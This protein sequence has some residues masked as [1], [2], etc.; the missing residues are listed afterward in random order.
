VPIIVK[1]F[2]ESLAGPPFS[3]RDELLARS[4]ARDTLQSLLVRYCQ[5]SIGGRSILIAGHRG[6]GKTTLVKSVVEEV[7]KDT[8]LQL[9][10]EPL[11]VYLHGPDLVAG[12]DVLGGAKTK[13]ESPTTPAATNVFILR[14]G[15]SQVSA[16]EPSADTDGVKQSEQAR[17]AT[18]AL[19]QLTVA[20]HQAF[21]THIGWLMQRAAHK[22][23]R[24]EE[25]AQFRLDVDRQLD[26]SDLRLFWSRMGVLEKGLLRRSNP[27]TAVN[28]YHATQGTLEI[29]ALASVS[30]AYVRAIAKDVEESE[31]QELEEKRERKQEQQKSNDRKELVNAIAGLLSGGAVGAGVAANAASVPAKVLLGSLAFSIA[32]IL[33]SSILNL[34]TVHSF[35]QKRSKER[36]V[37]YDDSLG[38]L[39]LMVPL[40][41]RRVQDAGL[42][43]VFV[44]DELD[45]VDGLEKNM[46]LLL[47]QLKHIVADKSFTCFLVDRQYFDTLRGWETSIARS[48][49]LTFFGEQLYIIMRP[50]DWHSYMSQILEVSESHDESNE[51]MNLAAN[52]LGYVLLARAKMHAIGVRRELEKL[53]RHRENIDQIALAAIDILTRPD[54][55]HAFIYQLAVEFLLEDGRLRERVEAEP[56]FLQVAYDALYYLLNNWEKGQEPNWSINELQDY[57]WLC[58]GVR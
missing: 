5:R 11:F 27:D 4:R 36:K 25:A 12:V 33:T 55:Q 26:V 44:V 17:L 10:A 22:V 47:R 24:L 19:R 30:E 46:E 21:T 31:G 32:T 45:K 18:L 34:T 39:E 9:D 2:S 14:D 49:G 50:A 56:T 7:S 16:P 8:T 57:L 40:L 53:P 20:L 42:A 43:P 41:I 6:A 51:L 37:I 58:T 13:E 38:S 15:Q 3:Q 52:V 54:Y 1:R 35:S 28:K 23:D 48:Q 29:V